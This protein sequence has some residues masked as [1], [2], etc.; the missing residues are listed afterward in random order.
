M[1]PQAIKDLLS[2]EKGLAGGAL[3]IA[4]TVL[5]ALGKMTVD[6]WVTYTEWIFGIYAGTK[7]VTSAVQAMSGKPS[8]PTAP[9]APTA[10]T[11]EKKA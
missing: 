2:S 1:I 4:A 3:I 9:T 7:T 5:A 10:T 6:A 8:A 11:P